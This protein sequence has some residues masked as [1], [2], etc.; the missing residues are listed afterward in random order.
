VRRLAA[1]GRAGGEA[2]NPDNAHDDTARQ[3]KTLRALE[4]NDIFLT[5]Y[6]SE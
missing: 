5:F 4:G 1:S 6:V 3:R 2:L